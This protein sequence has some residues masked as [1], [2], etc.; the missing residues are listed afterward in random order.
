MIPPDLGVY[1]D[2]ACTV[3]VQAIDFGSFSPGENVT[4]TFYVRN[5]GSELGV[6]SLATQNWNPSIAKEYLVFSWN[7]EGAELPGGAVFEA[8]FDIRALSTLTNS[9]GISNFSFDAVISLSVEEA[10]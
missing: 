2:L 1:S 3:E 10:A 7:L 8:H 6:L 5:E 9:S 4:R